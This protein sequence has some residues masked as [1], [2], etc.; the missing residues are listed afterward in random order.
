MKFI[1]NASVDP[2]FCAL[3]DAQNNLVDKIEWTTRK[4]DGKN[5]FD[6]LQKHNISKLNLSLIGG[7]SGPGGFSSLRV[8]ASIL[9]VISLAKNIPIHQVRADIWVSEILKSNNHASENLLLN[10]FSDGVF[11]ILK[12]NHEPQTT[13][14]NSQELIRMTIQEAAK[15]F[16]STPLFVDFLPAEKKELIK[17]QIKLSLEDSEKI[18]L[19]V[20]EKSESQKTFIPD[21]E[22]PPV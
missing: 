2:H 13:N 8:T 9:N 19:E 14:H 1:I 3:F 5:I 20:L 4:T 22:F 15:K 11:S 7:I 17:E 18:L 10:S 21:Y 12:T 6:F 16:K